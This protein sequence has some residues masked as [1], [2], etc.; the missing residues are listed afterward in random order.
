MRRELKT[1]GTVESQSEVVSAQT[2]MS[3]SPPSLEMALDI[4]E[5]LDSGT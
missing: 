3:I 1:D 4:Q 2:T 5:A